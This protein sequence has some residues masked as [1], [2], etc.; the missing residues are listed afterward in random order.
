MQQLTLSERLALLRDKIVT[1][2]TPQ[3]TTDEEQKDTE[4][5]QS[6]SDI[7]DLV[8]TDTE[9]DYFY[10]EPLPY[11]TPVVPQVGAVPYEYW[12]SLA[13]DIALGTAPPEQMCEA[14]G[15]GLADLEMLRK[16]PYFS[17]LLAAKKQEVLE[18]GDN[19]ATITKFRIIANMGM[20]EFMRRLTSRHTSDRDFHAML[21]TSLEMGRYL[22]DK[23]PTNDVQIA[24]GNNGG[25]GSGMTFNIY[26]IPGL[27]HLNKGEPKDVTKVIDHE[28]TIEVIE[29]LPSIDMEEL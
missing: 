18:A 24:I 23:N 16:S 25:G 13:Y 29:V 2:P 11:A 4:P 22:P 7:E 10:K 1:E 12:E 8:D 20:R 6:I 19:A 27:D 14:Y 21:R 26:G 15:I 3:E 28:E 9:D 5:T 17:K